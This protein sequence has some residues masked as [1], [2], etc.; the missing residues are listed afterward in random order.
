MDLTAAGTW[1]K[2][3][4]RHISVLEMKAVQPALNA[5]YHQIMEES[6]VLSDNATVVAYVKKLGSTASRVICDLA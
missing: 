1:M 5:L 6:V 2:E 4:S 3:E